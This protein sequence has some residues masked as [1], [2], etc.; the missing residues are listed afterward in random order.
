MERL[1]SVFQVTKKMLRLSISGLILM[2][3]K[4]Q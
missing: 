4:G 1:V 2:K 3:S